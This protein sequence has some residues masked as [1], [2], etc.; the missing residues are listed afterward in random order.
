MLFCYENFKRR[1]NKI[2]VFEYFNLNKKDINEKTILFLFVKFNI[3]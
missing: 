1:K 2:N 3:L